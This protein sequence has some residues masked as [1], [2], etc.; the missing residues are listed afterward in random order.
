M[1]LIIYLLKRVYV[2]LGRG[3]TK[4]RKTAGGRND[5][6][7]TRRY[8]LAPRSGGPPNFWDKTLLAWLELGHDYPRK[9]LI[10]HQ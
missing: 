10:R 8:C 2:R 4:K 7:D 5:R 3:D 9:L 1:S 6:R